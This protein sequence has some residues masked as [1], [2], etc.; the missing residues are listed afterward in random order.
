MQFLSIYETKSRPRF[1]PLIVHCADIKMAEEIAEFPELARKLATA[2]WPGPLTM[3]LPKQPDAQLS[4]LVTAGLDT[5]R[6]PFACA[7]Y[8]ARDDQ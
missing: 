8:C 7:P 5:G 3:V 2:F 4:D 1:N 6:D